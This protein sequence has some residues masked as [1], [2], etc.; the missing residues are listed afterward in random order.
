MAGLSA[1]G[2]RGEKSRASVGWAGAELAHK[3]L[4]DSV[5]DSSGERV[6]EDYRAEQRGKKGLPAH[7]R[8][9]KAHLHAPLSLD[10]WG[11]G[12]IHHHGERVYLPPELH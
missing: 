12:S 5:A 7:C 8:V 11:P 9:F 1:W 6:A 10:V 3:G 4:Q 2:R